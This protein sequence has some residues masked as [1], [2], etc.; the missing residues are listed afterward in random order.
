MGPV[1][2]AGMN[3]TDGDIGPEVSLSI[4]IVLVLVS[5]LVYI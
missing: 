3:G 1:G 2:P 5:T 4:F